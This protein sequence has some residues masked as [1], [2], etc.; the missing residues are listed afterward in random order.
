MA[1]AILNALIK[2]AVRLLHIF[3]IIKN[4]RIRTQR[5]TCINPGL[6]KSIAVASKPVTVIF[7]D[8]IVIHVLAQANNKTA[9]NKIDSQLNKRIYEYRFEI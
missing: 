1:Q 4:T 3:P 9:R 5:N 7:F 8:G 6:P 2:K